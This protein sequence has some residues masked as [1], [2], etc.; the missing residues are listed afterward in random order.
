[1]IFIYTTDLHGNIEKYESVFNF[2]KTN[3]ISL[4][5]L[6]A[7][8]LPKD[9]N[10]LEIQKKFINGF[11]KQY[12]KKAEESSIKLLAFFGND[13]VYTRKKYFKQYGSLLDEVLY[14]FN[15]FNFTAYGY[16]CDYPFALKTA[17]KLDYRGWK[18]PFVFR[19]CDFDE[20]GYLEIKDVDEYLN[21]K[22]TIKEDLE[23]IEPKENTIMAIH[24]PPQSLGLDV[25]D[26]GRRVGS[27]SVLE[28]IE[29]NNEKLRLVLCG[30]IHESFEKSGI[31]TTNVKNTV[32]IQPGQSESKT[33]I[34]VIE[35]NDQNIKSDIFNI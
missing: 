22:T 29:K 14:S 27:K 32:V 5:H 11:L 15:G 23:K 21:K 2:A 16:T 8:I 3:N 4:I 26:D 20:R 30:H 25:C 35:I 6:G 7:D 9:S 18:R 34:V 31:W 33:T 17:C 19:A 12:Y 10:I 28:F 24:M 1:M 13:D